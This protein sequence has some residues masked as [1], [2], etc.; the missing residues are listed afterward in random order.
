M[1]QQEHKCPINA[2]RV[3]LHEFYYSEDPKT[4][5]CSKCHP[6]KLGTWLQQNL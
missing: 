1:S 4:M 5:M 6:C 3:T 2:A